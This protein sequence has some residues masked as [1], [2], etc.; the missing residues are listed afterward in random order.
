MKTYRFIVK[1]ILARTVEVD[2][3]SEF[4]AESAVQAMLSSG[5]LTLDTD[6]YS[7]TEIEC[8]NGDC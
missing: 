5:E 4:E 2:A 1:E 7:D 8:E 6:D 3:E